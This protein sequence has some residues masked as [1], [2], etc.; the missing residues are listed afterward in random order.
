MSS[1]KG[2]VVV[3]GLGAPTKFSPSLLGRG[4]GGMVAR[5]AAKDG[6][7]VKAVARDPNKYKEVFADATGVELVKGDVTDQASVANVLQGAAFCVFAAQAPDGVPASAVDRD[8][9]ILVARECEKV[10]AKLVLVSSVLVSKKNWFNPIRAFL[11]N[12]V[13]WAMM[14]MKFEGEEALR[15]QFKVRHVIVRPSGLTDDGSCNCMLTFNQGDSNTFGT[16]NISKLDV[17]KVIV[18]ALND[19]ASDYTTFEVMGPKTKEKMSFD[20]VFAKFTKDVKV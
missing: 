15:K 7:P 3:F 17:A 4:V 14:D 11:N 18:A 13:K 12:V 10:G 2:T 9:V 16:R 19:P 1:T 6:F 5:E 20:G 8:A